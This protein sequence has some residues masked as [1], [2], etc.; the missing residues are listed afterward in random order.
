M[1]KG[2]LTCVIVSHSTFSRKTI[3]VKMVKW[4]TIRITERTGMSALKKM[5]FTFH[6][7][8]WVFNQKIIL[9]WD[10]KKANINITLCQWE[11]TQRPLHFKQPHL[12]IYIASY[13][14]VLAF[15][16]WFPHIWIYYDKQSTSSTVLD[17]Q[18]K[19]NSLPRQTWVAQ[20]NSNCIMCLSFTFRC[21]SSKWDP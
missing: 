21:W 20:V 9:M 2:A 15:R 4:F 1:E 5:K 8:V 16:L 6:H 11:T 13:Y 10:Y 19:A 7:L 12:T 3:I 18:N 14:L 17:Y